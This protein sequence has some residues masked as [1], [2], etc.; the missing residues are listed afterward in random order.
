M[1]LT[2]GDYLVKHAPNLGNDLPK[3]GEQLERPFLRLALE[4]FEELF[5][6]LEKLL[7]SSTP[8]HSLQM[9]SL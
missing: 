3:E 9:A 6:G 8:E 1:L 7:Y 2:T 4:M 5:L